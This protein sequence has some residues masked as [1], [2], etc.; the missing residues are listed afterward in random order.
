MYRARDK[1]GRGDVLDFFSAQVCNYF[2]FFLSDLVSLN[3]AKTRCKRDMEERV[4]HAPCLCLTGPILHS[5]F[6]LFTT[7]T[8]LKPLEHHALRSGEGKQTVLL[9]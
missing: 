1:A 9:P 8:N 2:P 3:L 4:R 6:F 7:S 5:A